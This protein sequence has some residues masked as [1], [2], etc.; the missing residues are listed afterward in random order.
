MYVNLL[1]VTSLKYKS[2]LIPLVCEGKVQYMGVVWHM[3]IMKT[4][5]QYRHVF[6]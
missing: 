6:F 3:V 2:L 4:I 1:N 5:Q